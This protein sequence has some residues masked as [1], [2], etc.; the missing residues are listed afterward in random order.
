MPVDLIGRGNQRA[1]LIIVEPLNVTR[2]KVFDEAGQTITPCSTIEDPV[3]ALGGKR[4]RGLRR[5]G[6]PHGCRRLHASGKQVV[7]P[8]GELARGREAQP[9]WR[10]ASMLSVCECG[11]H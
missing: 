1:D 11:R 10:P 3:I 8:V 9:V 5:L 2:C 6:E 7:T 4:Q